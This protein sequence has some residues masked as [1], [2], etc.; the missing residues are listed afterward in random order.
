MV[1]DGAI[2]DV[3]TTPD[4]PPDGRM[5]DA[6][7]MAD[8]RPLDAPPQVP[9]RFVQGVSASANSNQIFATFGSL[10]TIGDLN[11]VGVSWNSTTVTITSIADT[12][13]NTYVQVGTPV[14]LAGAGYLAV[15]YAPNIHQGAMANKVTVS[16]SGTVAPMLVLAEYSGL[17]LT[18]LDVSHSA[19]NTN[20]AALDSGAATTTNAHDLL[21]GIAAATRNVSAGTGYTPRVSSGLDLIEDQE[22][23][24]TGSYHATASLGQNGGWIMTMVAFK[25]LN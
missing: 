23:S 14:L 22:V 17:A 18:P 15:Y 9:V 6:P 13:L 3:V 25:A 12:D 19:A 16:F 24:A 11:V 2:T 20:G 4:A 1:D 21:V 5:I 8:A 7:A 10:E